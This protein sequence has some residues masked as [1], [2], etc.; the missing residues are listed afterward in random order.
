MTVPWQPPSACPWPCLLRSLWSDAPTSEVL[1]LVF[2]LLFGNGTR[3]SA[4]VRTCA[5]RFF[6]PRESAAASSDSRKTW[7]WPFENAFAIA[8]LAAAAATPITRWGGSGRWY[9]RIAGTGKGVGDRRK[10]GSRKKGRVHAGAT[11]RSLAT[12]RSHQPC[13]LLG[14]TYENCGDGNQPENGSDGRRRKKRNGGVFGH[15]EFAVKLGCGLLIGVLLSNH[16]WWWRRGV[17]SSIDGRSI[18]SGN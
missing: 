6:V 4:V 11:P 17:L 3:S 7:R 14:H 16:G 12:Q 9:G 8:T 18:H 13:K 10:V 1:V 2:V 5:T 15:C